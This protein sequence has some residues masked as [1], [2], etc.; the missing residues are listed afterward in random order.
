MTRKKAIN[1]REEDPKCHDLYNFIYTISWKR[2]NYH[3]GVVR[4]YQVLGLEGGCNT[5]KGKRER[6]VINTGYGS[7]WKIY[8]DI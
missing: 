6:I 2:Q 1:T 3:D 7:R 4:H 8:I 5:K